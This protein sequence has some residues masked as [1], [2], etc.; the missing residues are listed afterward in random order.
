M[1]KMPK[2]RFSMLV[3]AF[4]FAV[5]AFA[6]DP[7]GAGDPEAAYTVV[8]N[9]R[10]D[11]IVAQLGIADSAKAIRVRD[12]IAGQY[13]A[14]RTIHEARDTRVQAVKK[15]AG[16]NKAAA[17]AGV[18]AATSEANLK[19][20]ANHKVF[21]GRLLAELTPEQ[22]DKV[23]DGLT[24][25]VVPLTYRVYREMLPNLTDEQQRQILAWLYEAREYAMDAGT[26]NEKH[27]WFGKYKGRINNYLA[28]AGIDMKKAERDMAQRQKAAPA[29]G[30]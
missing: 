3:L 21:L 18:Q 5:P 26:S 28:K 25:G 4:V 22:I 30:K 16:A 2:I 20:D 29:G 14:L 13:R 23:K 11:A 12:I 8:I 19:L 17:D 6:Q 27:G 7:E 24:Y 15:Q 9:E 1:N 10:A